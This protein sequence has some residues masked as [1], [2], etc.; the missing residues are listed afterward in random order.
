MPLKSKSADTA[1]TD[2]LLTQL[3]G[4]TIRGVYREGNCIVLVTQDG[5][6]ISF[7]SLGGDSDPAFYRVHRADVKCAVERLREQHER[8]SRQA[9]ALVKLQ[10]ELS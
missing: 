7:T 9:L 8:Q 1:N 5:Y 6:G 2:E 10:G 4:E 3:I